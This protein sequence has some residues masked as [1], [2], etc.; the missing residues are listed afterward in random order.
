M[1]TDAPRMMRSI[2]ARLTLFYTLI[3]LVAMALF[4]TVVTW[5]LSVEFNTDH[6]RFLQ[7]KTA[8]MQTDLNEGHGQPGMLI[9][10]INK[11]TAASRVREYQ[12]RVLTADGRPLGETPGMRVALP[13]RIFPEANSAATD[14]RKQQVGDRVYALTSVSLQTTKQAAPLHVQIALDITRDDN[15]LSELRRTMWLAFA[16]LAPLLALAGRWVSA[17][18]LAPLA[19]IASAAREVIPTHLSARIP[20]TPPW[21]AELSELVLV[22]N[23]MLTRLEEAFARLSRFSADL[24]HELRTPLSNMSGAL[25]VCLLRPRDASEY[26]EVLESNL[27]ECRR[28]GGLIDNLLFM[29]RAERAETALRM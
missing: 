26:R 13:S 19:R 7:A 1:P 14:A 23:A 21:P 18:G 10:E 5:K 3:V 15:L 29:A 25:E 9:G 11:E 4:A 27:D 24:A 22:F 28:L 8:E 16:L 17:R 2:G 6:L 12:A 20:T